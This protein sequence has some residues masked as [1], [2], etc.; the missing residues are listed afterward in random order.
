MQGRAA[1]YT[2]AL[3][4]YRLVSPISRNHIQTG[5]SWVLPVWLV[6][7]DENMKAIRNASL[8]SLPLVALVLLAV[9]PAA[10]GDT[11]VSYTT[12]VPS[13]NTDLNSVIATPAITAFNTS[14]GTLDSVTVSYTGSEDSSFQLTNTASGSETFHFSETLYYSLNNANGAINSDVNGLAPEIDN[15]PLT[16]ITLASEGIKSYGPFTSSTAPATE[17]ITSPSELADFE[18]N[19]NLGNFLITT[20]TDTNF[21]GGGGNIKL[22]G[23]TTADG[24]VT[25]TYDYTPGPPPVVPEPGTLVMFGTG[26]LG[27]AGLL[28]S[29]FK[30]SR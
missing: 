10:Y 11:I 1:Y 18:G 7:E 27:L 22:T 5:S 2:D 19:G 15:V 29:K 13:Q 23:S 30:H 3:F 17:T 16:S 4:G 20:S 14:L 25:V 26:I 28:R 21:V 24:S 8:L 6:E 12:S 9:A